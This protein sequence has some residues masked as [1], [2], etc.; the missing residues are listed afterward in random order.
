MIPRRSGRPLRRSRRNVVP[1]TEEIT[2]A[3]AHELAARMAGGELSP[4]A[5]LDACL[6]RIERLD[7]RI[8]AFVTVLAEE[9]RAA[10]R[11]SEARIRRGEARPLE[12]VP[13]PIKDEIAVR[14]VRLGMGSKMAPDQ[15]ATDEAVLVTRLR[16]AGAVVVGTT[17]LPEFGTIP[18]TEH[19]DGTATHNPW[20]L[21]RTPGGS[22]GG[23][24]AAVAS[25]M[26]P[27]AHG[28]DGGGSLRIP[29]SCNGLF[30]VKPSRG[31]I[32]LAPVHGEYPLGLVID[33]FITRSVRDNALLL[34]TVSGYVTG[35]PYWA[36]PP[37]RPFV[38]EVGAPAGR[39][40]IGWTVSPPI[41]VPVAEPCVAA[42]RDAAAL[43]AE[44]GHQVDE[45]T[46]DWRDDET[47]G[48]FMQVW[49]VLIGRDVEELRE[50]GG[51]PALVEPHNH[52]LW[53]QGRATPG[54]ELAMTTIKAH[55]AARRIV[56]TFDTYDVVLCPSLAQPPMRLGEHF[57][58]YADNPAAPLGIAALFTPFTVTANLTGLPAV[59]LPLAMHEG[60]PIGVQAIGGPADEATLLRLSAQIEAARPWADRRP[61]ALD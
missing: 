13:I 31:R 12:G 37:D 58:G 2:F 55:A 41:D 29:A 40:R 19:P 23:A 39:L 53:E 49:G 43:C 51:D 5:L 14:G 11:D 28:R 35:D 60:L 59:S 38:D 17:A 20:D 18:T 36:P 46:P 61:P 15:P 52:L 22:S 10:A 27:V 1:A 47:L 34:D 26:V 50:R 45:V 8:G 42:V 32:S 24:G 4:V 30:T 9:A 7:P 6:A 48:Q 33:G 54:T 57:A 25:G 16:E 56:R 44:L 3:P 21:S